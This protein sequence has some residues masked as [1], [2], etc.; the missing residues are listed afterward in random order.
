MAL[1][2]EHN[3]ADTETHQGPRAVRKWPEGV[4]AIEHLPCMCDERE[5]TETKRA[6]CRLQILTILQILKSYSS[7]LGLGSQ[8]LSLSEPTQHR[9]SR[10]W[11]PQAELCCSP[12]FCW[13]FFCWLLMPSCIISS[14]PYTESLTF[15]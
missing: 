14:G 1:P 8:E 13:A 11:V 2:V 12:F 7:S 3:W 10:T 15:Y 9:P 5:E 4:V 6:G